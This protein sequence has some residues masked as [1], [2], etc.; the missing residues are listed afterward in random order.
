MMG[1]NE[2]CDLETNREANLDDPPNFTH[3]TSSGR[4]TLGETQAM[5]INF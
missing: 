5:N 3:D 1:A 2:G 4:A